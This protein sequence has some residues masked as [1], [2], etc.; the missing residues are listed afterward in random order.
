MD[1]ASISVPTNAARRANLCGAEVFLAVAARP[2]ASLREDLEILFWDTREAMRLTDAYNRHNADIPHLRTVSEE[3]FERGVRY[4]DENGKPWPE[5]SN[6]ILIVS[7]EGGN[8]L[9]CAHAAVETD[10]EHPSG[11]GLIRYFGFE[12]NRRKAGEGQPLH[13]PTSRCSDRRTHPR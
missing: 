9:G 6:E 11:L 8:I 2:I 5:L 12:K 10:D 13:V 4:S 7:R 3:Q 1:F